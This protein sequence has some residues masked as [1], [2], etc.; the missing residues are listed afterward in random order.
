MQNAVLSSASAAFGDLEQRFVVFG[1]ADGWIDLLALGSERSS[2]TAAPPLTHDSVSSYAM[3]RLN[4]AHTSGV[5]ALVCEWCDTTS[6]MLVLSGG[7]DQYVVASRFEVSV[8]GHWTLVEQHRT[9]SHAAAVRGVQLQACDRRTAV[10]SDD[11]SC[12]QW[13]ASTVLTCANDERLVTHTLRCSP[14][15]LTA[16]HATATHVPE[17]GAIASTRHSTVV[18]GNGASVLKTILNKSKE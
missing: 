4:R 3:V 13:C 9:V 12:A 16:T 1:N 2:R 7:D 10:C 11:K 6:S 17:L 15:R 8:R 5:V 14:L 18:V